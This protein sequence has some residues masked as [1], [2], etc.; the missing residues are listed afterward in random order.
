MGAVIML[1]WKFSP[2]DYFEESIELSRQDYTM[3]IVDGQ[4]HAKIDSAIFEADPE[5]R[6]RLHDTL[7]DMFL[8]VQLLTHS[9]YELS[10]STKIRVQPDGHRDII[11][12]PEPMRIGVSFGTVDI[13][14][15][16]KY[17]HV[18]VDSKRDRIKKM[19][20]LMDLIGIH[21]PTDSLLA[22]LLKSHA[23]AVQDPDNE[24]VHLYEIRDALVQKFGG[25][26]PTRIRLGIA[27]SQWS[28]F[29]QLCNNEP[30]LQGRHR[31]KSSGILRDA[32]Q[33]ELTEARDIARAMIEAYLRYLET[34]ASLELI[35]KLS[36]M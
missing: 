3:T 34:S 17:G 5:I 33:A 26:G 11:L 30:L 25:Q 13:Q 10:R 36:L 7:N 27:S 19:N 24:L 32:T 6:Q 15:T 21:R 23:S 8:G 31:G 4:V 20:R 12:E 28:R 18:I 14:V 22:S 16:D 29:G 1:E 9:A 2:L 35:P